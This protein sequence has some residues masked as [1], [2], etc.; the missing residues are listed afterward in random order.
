MAVGGVKPSNCLEYLLLA[1]GVGMARF[2]ELEGRGDPDEGVYAS[3]PAK[4]SCDRL[5]LK[6]KRGSGRT[7]SRSW[8]STITCPIPFLLIRICFGS[9]LLDVQEES[10][11]VTDLV[12][13]HLLQD[14]LVHLQQVL[15][16]DII[17]PE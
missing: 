2:A 8:S 5:A 6:K 14:S 9:E 12:Y 4:E 16:I 7:R 13:A 1:G 11:T 10:H 17:L 3:R 15:A